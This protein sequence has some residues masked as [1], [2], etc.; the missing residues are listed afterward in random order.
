MQFDHIG[1]VCRSLEDGRLHLGRLLQVERWTAEFADTVNEVYVQ[2]G[3]DASQICYEIIAPLG[4][5][6]PV[7]AA[8]QSGSRILNH[9]AYRVAD[10]D[11][12]AAQLRE[13]RCVAAGPARP[14]IAYGNRRIQFFMTP[15]GFLVELIEAPDHAHRFA[16]LQTERVAG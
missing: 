2:F 4:A 15:L 8:L 7:R 11:A 5:T 6:S 14:A 16:V 10:L 1:I 3:V 12:R 13:E 9:V